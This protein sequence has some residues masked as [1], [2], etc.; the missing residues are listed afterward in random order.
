MPALPWEWISR[1]F[2]PLNEQ[3]ITLEDVKKGPV[4][5]K[6]PKIPYQ[7]GKFHTSDGKFQ[8]ITDYEGRPEPPDGLN[9]LMVKVRSLLPILTEP[10]S[11][12]WLH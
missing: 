4:K 8:F 6:L 12:N 1:T 11:M 2:G 3:G 5:R 9:L 10:V 7:D